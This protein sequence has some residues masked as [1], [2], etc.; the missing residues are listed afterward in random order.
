MTKQ[1][2]LLF[3]HNSTKITRSVTCIF[4][5][6]SVGKFANY[7]TIEGTLFRWDHVLCCPGRLL[8]VIG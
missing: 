8:V 3:K 7:I 2:R 6:I 1:D 4:M 5:S